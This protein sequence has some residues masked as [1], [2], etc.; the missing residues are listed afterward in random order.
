MKLP[1]TDI[2]VE[3]SNLIREDYFRVS[4]SGVVFDLLRNKIYKDPVL[5]IC[6]EIASNARDAHREVGTPD[7]PIEIQLPGMF[8]S[9]LIIKDFGLGISKDRM[10]DIFLEY[11]SSTKRNCS[12]QQGAYGLG[13]KTP[14]AYSD[15]FT[16]ITTSKDDGYK[17]TYNAYIDETGIGKVALVSESISDEEFG[18]A[19]VIPVNKKDFVKFAESVLLVTNFWN[20]RP[21]IKNVDTKAKEVNFFIKRDNWALTSY[22]PERKGTDYY[23]TLFHTSA[24]ID[25][26]MYE[27]D[28]DQLLVSSSVKSFFKTASIVLYFNIG[29]LS[30][31]AS[32]DA[33]HYNENT[34]S[35]L[36]KRLSELR[37]I[38]IGE[39]KSTIASQHSYREASKFFYDICKYLTLQ[40]VELK[41]KDYTVLGSLYPADLGVDKC[42]M[43]ELNGK[44]PNKISARFFSTCKNDAIYLNDL[45]VKSTPTKYIAKLFEDNPSF[46][47]VVILIKDG[48][49]ASDKKPFLD[50]LGVKLLSDINLN[51]IKKQRSI[52]IK[53][54]LNV[55]GYRLSKHS[56]DRIEFS[57]ISFVNNNGGVYVIVDYANSEYNSEGIV[58]DSYNKL[59]QFENFIGKSI[60]GFTQGKEKKLSKN[61]VSLKKALMDKL[62]EYDIPKLI[63]LI[64]DQRFVCSLRSIKDDISVESISLREDSLLKSYILQSLSVSKEYK[65]LSRVCKIIEH[66]NMFTEQDGDLAKLHKEVEGRYPILL[67]LDSRYNDLKDIVSYVNVVDELFALKEKSGDNK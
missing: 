16:I 57:P 58:I 20:V 8:D 50:E 3:T 34:K 36:S 29:E 46:T 24:V 28:F 13:A 66:A 47:N 10:Y 63:S 31:I 15:T 52:Y 1:E 53:N 26:I 62:S 48:A 18:T 43:Y 39:I 45:N 11:G 59:S 9:S 2:Q 7:R 40:D 30:L 67:S 4:N 54:D 64:N 55:A 19:I 23:S 65:R 37:P 41:W 21:I 12:E 22:K 35:V 32:R 42:N 27:I 17:R 14:F 49:I 51:K 6:R 25:G 61:W 60:C 38:I 5:A 56:R 33:I 44:V